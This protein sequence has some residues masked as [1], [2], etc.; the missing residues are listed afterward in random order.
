MVVAGAGGGGEGGAAAVASA[1]TMVPFGALLLLSRVVDP[2][3]VLGPVPASMDPTTASA[4]RLLLPESA[5]LVV[6]EVGEGG[7]GRTVLTA[8]VVI[9]V[10]TAFALVDSP[11]SVGAVGGVVA[12]GEASVV[13]GDASDISEAAPKLVGVPKA[14]SMTTASRSALSIVV[15][16]AGRRPWRSISPRRMFSRSVCESASTGL[17]PVLL[18][19]EGAL[20][21]W[22]GKV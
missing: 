5:T 21:R 9:A 20:A 18:L 4:W 15:K 10:V 17:W 7:G 6:E 19:E 12:D 2:C 16:E 8:L 13:M 11:T 1:T 14:A 22:N 3:A